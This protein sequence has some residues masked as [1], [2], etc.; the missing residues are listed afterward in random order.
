MN[1]QSMKAKLILIG[2]IS[3]FALLVV[4]TIGLWG[5]RSG[6]GHI[7]EIGVVRLPSILGLGIIN[8]GQTAVKAANLTTAIWENDFSLE[9]KK[10]FKL[11]LSQQKAA[12][13]SVEKGWKIYEPLPQTK[14]EEQLWKAFLKD[15]DA[16]KAQVG[17]LT[18][19][20]ESL[21]TNSGEVQ[22]KALFANFYAEYEKV[23]PLFFAA[24]ASLDKVV[25]LNVKIAEESSKLAEK[26]ASQAV[27][28]MT[29]MIVVSLILLI[30]AL[31]LIARGI[32]KQLGGEPAYVR[33]VMMKL[34]EGD[35]TVNVVT[36]AN[37]TESMAFAIK[38]MISKTSQVINETQVVV[39]A[40]AQ[41]DLSKNIE[42]AG[43]K[44]FAIDLSN[45]V[46]TMI[47]KLS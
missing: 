46:N 12:W 18:L 10:G 40:A 3:V 14:E 36:Q 17:K 13:E 22:Q 28:L 27:W 7:N 6:Q 30:L 32:L 20:M 1:L 38:T 37:D 16:W 15:W 33:D 26:D 29:L 19:T 9:G 2:L 31:L 23:R 24:E 45:S 44:G 41:G 5:I 39:G 43:K 4:A 42:L 47:S 21:S 35:L 11:A 34:A 8:E 25:Q